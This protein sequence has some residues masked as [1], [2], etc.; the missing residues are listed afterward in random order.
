MEEVRPVRALLKALAQQ[1]WKGSADHPLL[2]SLKHLN[3]LYDEGEHA[4]PVGTDLSLVR[5][6]ACSPSRS[7]NPSP[8]ITVASGN[9]ITRLWRPKQLF[10]TPKTLLSQRTELPIY[11]AS[12]RR[13]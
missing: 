11:S 13:A 9:K 5:V 7:S 10:R 3:A 8:A 2:E 1:P 12:Y 4:L 6:W